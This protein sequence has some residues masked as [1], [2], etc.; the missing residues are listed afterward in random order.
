MISGV[1]LAVALVVQSVSPEVAAHVRAGMNAQKE[2]RQD[3]A[4]AEFKKVTELA[5]TLAAAYVNL[6]AAYMQAHQ[7]NAAISPLRKSLELD[8]ELVGA[9]QMLGFAL[10]AQGY[11]AESV[12]YLEKSKS[13]EALG[14]ALVKVGRLQDAIGVLTHAM[15]THPDDP[16]LLYYLGRASGLLSKESF[17]ALESDFPNSA[18][19]HQALGENY[20]AIKQIPEAEKEYL[21][22]LRTRPDA[23]GIHLSLGL[24]YEAAVDWAKAEEQYHAEADLAPGDAE[25]AYRLGNALLQEGKPQDAKKELD[26][27]NVLRPDMPET[28]HALGKA[29]ALTGDPA[30]AEKAWARVIALTKNGELAAQAH[31]QLA[32]LYQKQG[33]TEEAKR[34]MQEYRH[35]QPTRP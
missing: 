13:E 16:E 24:L 27:A 4:I 12:P 34:E 30:D 25:P 32:S 31:F 1:V 5:P 8:S 29:D 19:A 22:A 35:L 21:E 11:A 18:R 26:R 2:G 33:K 23:P 20:S 14:I 7:Y 10:L 17:D 15:G 6:G 9:R 3:E 28:L